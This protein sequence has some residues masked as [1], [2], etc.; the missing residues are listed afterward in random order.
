M[1]V[2]AVELHRL[3]WIRPL[4]AAHALSYPTVSSLFA[5][6]P[7]DPVAWQKTIARVQRPRG[8][9]DVISA[10]LARQLMRRGAPEPARAAANRLTDP[11]TVVVVTGQQ[12]GLF[13]GPLYTLLKGI[14]AVRLARELS[15][16]HGVPVVPL[17]WAEAE[18]HDWDEVRSATF[19]GREGG[20][21]R[22]TLAGVD[23]AGSHSC[24]SL[25]LSAEVT[26]AL[27][28][29]EETLPATDFT[30]D[31]LRVLRRCYAPDE[32]LGTA[33][34][35]WLDHLLGPLGMPVCEADDPS[36]KPLVADLFAHELSAP[37]RT[38][39]LVNTA[40]H[41]MQGLGHSPQL[42]PGDDATGLF[43]LDSSGRRPIK[44]ADP[45]YQIGDRSH[46]VA[47]LVSEASAHPER[48]S[49]NVLLRPIVQDR[50]FPTICYVAGPSELAYQAQLAEVYS[51]FGVQRPILRA[52][53]SATLVDPPTRRLFEK[54]RIHLEVLQPQ[55]DA[56]L[57]ELLSAT[58]PTKIVE[59][60][61]GIQAQVAQG[62]AVLRGELGTIDPTL[63]GAVDTTVTKIDDTLK[64]L[65]GKI[66]QASKRKEETFRR[67]FNHARSLTFPDGHP[68][69]RA[70]SLTVFVNRYG[71]RL[72]DQ[73]L[74]QLPIDAGRHYV[75]GV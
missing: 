4:V 62:A 22:I 55:S 45:V 54:Y 65:H 47:D 15:Q 40:G 34:A 53:V 49:P 18:D 57:N 51:E 17:F 1:V 58:L 72:A 69:E 42:Q 19:L 27:A 2:D 25:R 24:G 9:S 56:A 41:L 48:F 33:F 28:S 50:L 6:N 59:T 12:V 44:F 61:T 73:L 35:R 14:T 8:R 60:I 30:A 23:G 31:V 63:I 29:L 39:Q 16:A 74:D 37:R 3:P 43:Y 10:V 68:Q 20:S 26:S 38:S 32:R 46:C 67:Q 71:S 66:I 21:T 52:R 11:R 36:A 5:G 75:L 64:S 70:L 7:A 13:G